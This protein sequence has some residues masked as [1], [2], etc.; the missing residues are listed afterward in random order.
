VAVFVSRFARNIDARAIAGP[1]QFFS[2]LMLL[3]LMAFDPPGTLDAHIALNLASL[4]LVSS[5]VAYLSFASFSQTSG[6]RRP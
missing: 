3:P 5:G 4:A 6:H 2:G 1:S